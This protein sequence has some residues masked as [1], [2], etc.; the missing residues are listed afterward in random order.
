MAA[1]LPLGHSVPLPDTPG[2]AI[3]QE[4]NRQSIRCL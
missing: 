3:H 4:L 2:S 1:A